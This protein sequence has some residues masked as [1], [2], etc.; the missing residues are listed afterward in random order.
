[1]L[2][3]GRRVDGGAQVEDGGIDPVVS[4]PHPALPALDHKRKLSEHTSDP[5]EQN[6]LLHGLPQSPT[7][8]RRDGVR[9]MVGDHAEE[10]GRETVGGKL[11]CTCQ[12]FGRRFGEEAHTGED[13]STAYGWSTTAS[14]AEV[15]GRR[16]RRAADAGEDGGPAS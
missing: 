5:S 15:S 2:H 14:G 4:R 9:E 6:S 3:G 10:G 11:R 16:L 8:S 1:M 12:G 13:Q 7:A